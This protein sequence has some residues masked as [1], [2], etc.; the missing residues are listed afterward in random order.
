MNELEK[1]VQYRK[2]MYRIK[3]EPDVYNIA[4]ALALAPEGVEGT[5]NT[6]NVTG[7]CSADQ[8]CSSSDS[9]IHYSAQGNNTTR[10]FVP[11]CHYIL[12]TANTSPDLVA[13]SGDVRER[14]CDS[15][16]MCIVTTLN[17]GLRNGGGIGDI[18]RAPSNKVNSFRPLKYQAKCKVRNLDWIQVVILLNSK[19][20]SNKN[21]YE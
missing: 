9:T 20:V 3:M 7:T 19:C 18:L 10:C 1:K 14:A 5:A 13:V 17:Q 8:N 2:E 16:V 4:A 6:V 21:F 15:L 12:C 11:L